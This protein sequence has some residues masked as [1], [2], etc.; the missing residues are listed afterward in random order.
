MNEIRNACVTV[1]L[2]TVSSWIYCSSQVAGC[3]LC[4]KLTGSIT[5]S[6]RQPQRCNWPHLDSAAQQCAPAATAATPLLRSRCCSAGSLQAAPLCWRPSAARYLRIGHTRVSDCAGAHGPDTCKWWCSAGSLQPAEH[7]A[8]CPGG[9]PVL[10]SICCC[11]QVPADTVHTAVSDCA[12]AHLLPDTC[13]W[14]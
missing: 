10:A 3:H 4:K 6:T 12:G 8:G 14:W 2:C 11:C 5:W 9:N 7:S 13:K 1:T